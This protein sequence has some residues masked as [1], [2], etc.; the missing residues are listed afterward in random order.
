MMK[1]RLLLK[2]SLPALFMAVAMAA[3][4]SLAADSCSFAGASS[5]LA[6][7]NLDVLSTA[8]ATTSVTITVRCSG[9][10]T[11]FLTSNNGLYP[12]GLIKR[13]KHQTLNE[14]IPYMLTF[15]PTS[16]NKHTTINGSGL[17]LNSDYINA[18]A[19]SYAD[20]VTIT[21]IP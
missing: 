21:I 13:M 15:S 6:F 5:A 14:Y 16:G 18:S 10:P 2:L 20:S 4:T 1:C 3:G 11:W 7:G 17:I 19:G 12:N 9:N 8:D